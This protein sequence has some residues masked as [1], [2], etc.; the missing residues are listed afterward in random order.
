MVQGIGNH[1]VAVRFPQGNG[2][3]RAEL[4]QAKQQL[5]ACINCDSYDTPQGKAKI[6]I[7]SLRVQRLKAELEALGNRQG[8][9]AGPASG[10]SPEA[11]VP[12]ESP[13]VAPTGDLGSQMDVLG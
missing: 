7:L 4:A 3:L 12:A 2:G 6:E 5:S 10:G 1:P 8:S 13:S 11:V 9:T